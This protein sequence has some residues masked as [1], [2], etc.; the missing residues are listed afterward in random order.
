MLLAVSAKESEAEKKL[1]LSVL[2]G[3]DLHMVYVKFRY[4]SSE[5]QSRKQTVRILMW[6]STAID[7]PLYIFFHFLF[8]T[9]GVYR[10]TFEV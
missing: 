9:S 2:N 3:T 7:F 6:I 5:A 10:F 4:K 1:E 8:F